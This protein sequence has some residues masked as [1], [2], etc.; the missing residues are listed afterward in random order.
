MG[1]CSR[2][3]QVDTLLCRALMAAVLLLLTAGPCSAEESVPRRARAVVLIRSSSTVDDPA[4]STLI[5]DSMSMELQARKIDVMPS[6]G[7]AADDAALGALEERTHA[8]FAL[9]GVYTLTGSEVQLN[10]RWLDLADRRE[11]GQASRSGQLDIDFDALVADLVDELVESQ[12][13]AIA[14]LPPEARVA[15]PPPPGPPERQPSAE[16]ASAAEP[17]PAAEP[18][19]AAGTAEPVAHAVG[20]P[21]AEER[22]APLAFSVGSAPFIATF[23]ALDYFRV[24][25]SVS[26]SG[27]YQMRA[28][29]GFVGIGFLTGICAFHGRGAYA[30]ADFYVVPVGADILFG[31]LTRGPLDFFLHL[32]GGPAV[33]VAKPAAGNLLAKVIPFVV[34]GIGF[35]WSA[36]DILAVSIDAS[37]TCFFDSSAVIMGFTP[38]LSVVLKL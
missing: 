38:S 13:E 12:K 16:P 17:V 21:A 31:A 25:L 10:V 4:L 32:G 14:S 36:L 33:L 5:A 29:G 30:Q 22:L 6:P 2:P 18:A 37:Y 26:L 35:A 20:P 9:S 27:R 23:T 28:P 19:P 24:G 11:A 8:D 3:S 34:G 15:E 1:R 7:A